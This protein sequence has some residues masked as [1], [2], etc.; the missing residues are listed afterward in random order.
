MLGLPG[1][2]CLAWS[3]D[4][5][6]A[7]AGF[8]ADTPVIQDPLWPAAIRGGFLKAQRRRIDLGKKRSRGVPT[9]GLCDNPDRW[10]RAVK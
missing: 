10:V 8:T 3:V 4:M 7:T 9:Q 5:T 2:P 1:E 6:A